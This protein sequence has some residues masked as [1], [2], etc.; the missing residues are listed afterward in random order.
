MIADRIKAYA[1]DRNAIPHRLQYL[2]ANVMEPAWA[3]LILDACLGHKDRPLIPV[4][5]FGEDFR[6]RTVF[7]VPSR[8]L[9]S[10]RMSPLV[11]EVV[12]KADHIQGFEFRFGGK[13]IVCV[14]LGLAV[15][16][17]AA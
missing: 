8:Y 9:P 16:L 5:I 17:S 4:V 7:L 1:E 13:G 12:V 10:A 14:E 11:V 6:E 2:V 3:F 15:T